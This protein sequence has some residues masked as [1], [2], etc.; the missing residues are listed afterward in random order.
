MADPVDVL[1]HAVRRY[2]F[3][4]YGESPG[5]TASDVLHVLV[6]AAKEYLEFLDMLPVP[7]EYKP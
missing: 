1:R 3:G 4:D 6:T 5:A 2:E 7:P